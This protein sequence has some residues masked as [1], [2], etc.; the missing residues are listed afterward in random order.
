MHVKNKI[1]WPYPRL[2]SVTLHVTRICVDDIDFSTSTVTSLSLFAADPGSAVAY[3]S[4][5][6]RCD[7]VFRS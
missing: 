5:I 4:Q 3:E 1:R 6:S 7:S 2:M